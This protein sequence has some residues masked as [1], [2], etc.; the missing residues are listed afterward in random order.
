MAEYLITG[1]N[2]GK[3][4]KEMGSQVFVRDKLWRTSIDPHF[5]YD[6]YFLLELLFLIEYITIW[7]LSRFFLT[8]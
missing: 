1:S 2:L 7:R 5:R 3:E 4:N 8:Y 6:A